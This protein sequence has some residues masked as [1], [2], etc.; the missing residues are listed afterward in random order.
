MPAPPKLIEL[1]PVFGPKNLVL[2]RLKRRK[3][4]RVAKKSTNGAAQLLLRA[5]ANPRR[6]QQ[7]TAA[8]FQT[9]LSTATPGSFNGKQILIINQAPKFQIANQ[10]QDSNYQSQ[11]VGYM[12]M[13]RPTIPCKN[14][15][16]IITFSDVPG[17]VSVAQSIG[18]L[19]DGY[20]TVFPNTTDLPK[21]LTFSNVMSYASKVLQFYAVVR[22]FV[23]QVY[24]NRDQILQSLAYIQNKVATLQSNQNDM[25]TFYMLDDKYANI[26]V[27][28]LRFEDKDIRFK[29][30]FTSIEQITTNFQI[31]AQAVFT[32]TSNMMNY[33]YMFLELVDQIWSLGINKF[34]NS[35]LN[36]LDK[37]DTVLNA[38]STLADI[39]LELKNAISSTKAALEN[40]ALFRDTIAEDLNNISA[41]AD[42]YQLAETV[43]QKPIWM[44]SGVL[45]VAVSLWLL[46]VSV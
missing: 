5:M 23:V 40:L 32:V 31:N 24:N 30:Y 25:L 33:V 6:A 29:Y 28:S 22:T 16:S 18:E 42:Q 37:I 14:T 41:L 20:Y 12:P 26:R 7:N 36:V 13:P 45:G 43:K 9:Q 1:D 38:L 8:D 4:E 35:F 46:L 19:Y 15:S 39:E 44:S 11:S 3:E 17:I 27:K 2:A 10:Q 34:S 21:N